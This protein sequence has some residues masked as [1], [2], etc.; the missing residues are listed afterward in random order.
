MPNLGLHIGFALEAAQRLG[1]PL[2]LEHRGSYLLGSTTP[3]VRLFAGWERARTH[4]FDLRQDGTG[5]GFDWM[6]RRHPRL[7]RSDKLSRETLAFVLGYVSHLSVDENW[8]VNVYRRFF[9]ADSAL[10]GDP[11]A[12]L[13]DRVL[14]F[15]LDRRERAAIV[16]LEEALAS[17]GGAYRG[18]AVGFIDEDLLRQWQEV[19]ISRAGRELPWGRFRGLVRRVRPAA[20]DAEVDR[21]IADVPELLERVRGHV[22]EAELL[23]FRELALLEF[24]ETARRYIGAAGVGANG[25]NA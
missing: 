17:I 14:Q 11:Q 25:W 5:A 9:G 24:V 6:L 3:D 1:H 20:N 23:R 7:R 16:D 22:D 15:E 13:L 18:V 4:F 19:V 12:N 21:I 8:I 10:A 2:A